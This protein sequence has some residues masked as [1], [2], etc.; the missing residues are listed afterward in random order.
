MPIDPNATERPPLVVSDRRISTTDNQSKP[1]EVHLDT[2]GRFEATETAQRRE[3]RRDV[4]A[5]TLAI[6]VFVAFAM[7]L[8]V[9]LVMWVVRGDVPDKMIAYT[10]DIVAVETTI[11][12]AIV[13]FYFS[14]TRV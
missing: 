12:A 4:V 6:G 14:Q 7:T 9:P 13:G 10:K 3:A 2:I 8:I 11:L 1:E 5:A